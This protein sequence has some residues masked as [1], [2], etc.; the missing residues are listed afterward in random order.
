MRIIL[1][2]RFALWILLLLSI[3]ATKLNANEQQVLYVGTDVNSYVNTMFV[4]LYQDFERATGIKIIRVRLEDLKPLDFDAAWYAPNGQPIDIINGQIS[5]RLLTYYRQG[6]IVS[7]NNFW[8]KNNLDR[9]FGYLKDQASF[10]GHI[11]GLPY[12]IYGW[13]IYYIKSLFKEVSPVPK[14]FEQLLTACQK[15]HDAGIIPFHS[16]LQDPWNEMAWFEYITLRTYGLAFFNQ[17]AEGKIPYTDKRIDYILSTWLRMYDAQCFSNDYGE[18]NW[19]ESLPIFFRKKIAMVFLGHSLVPHLYND[20]ITD[21]IDFFG[22]PKIED[23]PRYESSPINAF[24]VSGLSKNKPAAFE[25]MAFMASADNQEKITHPLGLLPAN[26]QSKLPKGR[27]AI[28]LADLILKAEGT[29]IFYDRHVPP[30]FDVASRPVFI[31]FAKTQNKE[32]FM[33]KMEALRLTHYD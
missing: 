12:I 29:S 2:Y 18:I 1:F 22:F 31:E 28:K 14:N 19:Q 30:K 21:D 11:L 10:E 17:L 5:R 20:V 6:K 9:D 15:F 24:H 4:P 27:F 33:H 3:A 25:F 32:K 23:I 26:K 8:K 16:M 7:L 13:H